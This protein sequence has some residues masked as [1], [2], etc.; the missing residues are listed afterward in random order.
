MVI[1][2][3]IDNIMSETLT[4]IDISSELDKNPIKY[5]KLTNS[6]SGD[7]DELNEWVQAKKS[8]LF[9]IFCGLALLF[10]RIF[11]IFYATIY[12]YFM[13]FLVIVLILILKEG[14]YIP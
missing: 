3:N 2:A 11:R 9:W 8:I 12:F 1:T 14:S 5:K 13:P 7:W 4:H 6:I 10:H